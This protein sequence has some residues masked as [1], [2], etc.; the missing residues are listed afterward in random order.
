MIAKELLDLA[1]SLE[2][3]LVVPR[4][5]AK[6]LAPQ[7]GSK[8]FLWLPQGW[9]FLLKLRGTMSDA[10]DLGEQ[11]IPRFLFG[12]E[13]TAGTPLEPTE[14]LLKALAALIPFRVLRVETLVAP[15]PQ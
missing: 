10:A 4:R 12:R 5:S 3:A 9:R 15:G 6:E 2:G 1:I 8:L 7:L 13:G 11:V 14:L